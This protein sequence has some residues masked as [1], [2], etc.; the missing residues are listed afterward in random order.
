MEETKK[1]LS[2]VG[3]DIL[4]AARNELY[5]NLPYLDAAL[6]ALARELGASEAL[7]LLLEARHRAGAGMARRFDL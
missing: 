2:A 6:C 1:D 4:H 5:M 3:L 7:A